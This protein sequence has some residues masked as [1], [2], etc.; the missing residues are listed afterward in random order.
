[1]A[2]LA[3]EMAAACRRRGDRPP[4]EVLWLVVHSRRFL[5]RNSNHWY[6]I[7]RCGA[8]EPNP[9]MLCLEIV[10]LAV[11]WMP[12]RLLDHAKF[13]PFDMYHEEVNAASTTPFDAHAKL[14]VANHRNKNCG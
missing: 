1:M 3:T 13:L 2:S 11:D 14:F 5:T 9:I 7:G 10:V 4:D 8:A 6:R 12:S